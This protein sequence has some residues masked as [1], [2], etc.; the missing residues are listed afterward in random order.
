M[1][2]EMRVQVPY[3]CQGRCVWCSTYKK[4]SRFA[5][6]YRQGISSRIMDFYARVVA[7]E[8]PR[9]LMLSGGEPILYPGISA[10]LEQVAPA[11]ER[12]YL[13]TSFQYGQ[14]DVSHLETAR[15]PAE[16]L[17]FVHSVYD[18]LPDNWLAGT[19]FPHEKYV[20]NLRQAREWP[21][22]KIIK[23]VL[24]HEHLEDEVALFR[25]LVEPDTAFSLEGKMLNNQANDYGR[26]FM[27]ASR[28]TL[29]RNLNLLKTSY[30]NRVQWENLERDGLQS[31]CLYWKEPELRF[32]LHRESPS[33]VLKYR[34]CGYFP[35]YFGYK[36]HVDRYR[37]GMFRK[38]FHKGRFKDACCDCRLKLYA[39]NQEKV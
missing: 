34:F 13:Y 35:P 21:G 1:F 8:Q 27:N 9:F 39:R 31:E 10:F 15:F 12:I 36:V 29:E 25:Q 20:A 17:V 37:P 2:Q 22:R 7:D 23:F 33:L 28:E 19:G 32:A 3:P 6:L 30:K 4:N 18:F 16:K 14:V 38:A 24:N 26:P 11:V 5:R